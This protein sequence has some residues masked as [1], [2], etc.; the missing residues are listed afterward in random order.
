M[1]TT[2]TKL[3][4]YYKFKCEKCLY[5]KSF[6][7]SYDKVYIFWDTTQNY[8]INICQI[9]FLTKQKDCIF[10]IFWN[11]FISIFVFCYFWRW[12]FCKILQPHQCTWLTS[13][14]KLNSRRFCCLHLRSFF[15]DRKSKR[16]RLIVLRGKIHPH[17]SASSLTPVA[18]RSWISTI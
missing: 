8:N 17:E 9:V 5:T 12:Y 10:E 13:Y 16:D 15:C 18:S 3:L 7:L 14:N 11:D 4:S 1:N 2:M 6:W